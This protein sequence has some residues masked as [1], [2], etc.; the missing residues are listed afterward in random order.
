MRTLSKESR[1]QLATAGLQGL[2]EHYPV[3]EVD[4]LLFYIQR[5]QN[6][7]TVVYQ[8]RT[9]SNGLIRT[10]QPLKVFWRKYLGCTEDT[11]INFIQKKLAYGYD[12]SF[13]SREALEVSIVSYPEYKIYVSKEEDRYVA[14]S[15]IN[16][17]WAHLSN[18][19]VYAEENG[20]FPIVKYLELYGSDK[21]SGLPCYERINISM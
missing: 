3:P 15:K 19:Y 13:I 5:N 20:A 12:Y 7:N 1:D 4:D 17:Q 6:A 2:P 21:S 8:V 9:D 16:G 11:D 18:V 10:Q 14:V